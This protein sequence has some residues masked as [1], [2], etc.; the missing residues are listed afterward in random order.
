[1]TTVRTR[2]VDTWERRTAAPLTALAVVFLAAYALPILVTDLPRDVTGSL[3]V[4]GLAIWLAFGFDYAVRLWLAD[5][6]LVYAR[7]HA[8][9]LVVIALPLLRPLRAVR[10][11][12]VLGAVSRRSRAGF[13][14]QVVAYVT[15]TVA[16]VT[17]V[18]ALAVLDAER[19]N[20]EANIVSFGDSLWWALTTMT[21]VGYGDRYPTTGEGRLVAV[22]LMLVGIGLLG[23]VTATL[24]SWFVE[25]LGAVEKAEEESAGELAA[26][27]EELRLVREQLQRLVERHG[28]AVVPEPRGDRHVG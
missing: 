2:R 27:R 21:T 15:A 16:L 9:D 23:V 20:P 25:K 14:G 17:F 13:R 7:K 11:V 6:R 19:R 12:A 24:A 4:L 5:R 28:E 1:M 10:L 26:V 18:A 8:L 22:G 3:S